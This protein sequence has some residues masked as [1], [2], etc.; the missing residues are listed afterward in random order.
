V[1]EEGKDAVN[2]EY[3]GSAMLERYLDPNEKEL[4]AVG[5]GSSSFLN[6]W[7]AFFRFR[8]VQTKQF[9]R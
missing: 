8:V 6:S 2:A 9:A 4:G 3:R 5:V 7:D 1:W